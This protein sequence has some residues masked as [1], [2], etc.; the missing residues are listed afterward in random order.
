[1]RVRLIY[2]RFW[3]EVAQA[4]GWAADD[5]VVFDRQ[6]SVEP[7]AQSSVASSAQ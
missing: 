5:L 1:V 4:K 2:R 3:Q 6:V 7:A